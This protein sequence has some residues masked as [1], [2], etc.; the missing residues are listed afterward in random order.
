MSPTHSPSSPS[1]PGHTRDGNEQTNTN[2]SPHYNTM[3]EW[4]GYQH[5]LSMGTIVYNVRLSNSASQWGL[6][7]L[8]NDD[9]TGGDNAEAD[10][11]IVLFRTHTAT[12]TY[13]RAKR[14]V[15]GSLQGSRTDSAV[16]RRHLEVRDGTDA[17]HRRLG[18]PE[19]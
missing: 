7:Q 15:I 6:K 10:G 17:L 18:V 5:A 13:V 16:V 4:A 11:G 8:S 3:A 9:A 2:A 14:V 12:H 1:I 19:V